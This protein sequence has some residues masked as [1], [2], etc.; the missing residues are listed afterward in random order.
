MLHHV[1]LSD[2]IT[3]LTNNIGMETRESFVRQMSQCE[4]M[5]NMV[6]AGNTAVL[7]RK[8]LTGFRKPAASPLKIFDLEPVFKTAAFWGPVLQVEAFV[9]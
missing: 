9:C 6:K 5:Q 8:S 3:V 2:V 1:L 7:G 4:G